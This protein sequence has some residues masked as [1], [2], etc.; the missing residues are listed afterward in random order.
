MQDNI[1]R[2]RSEK[3]DLNDWLVHEFEN[4]YSLVLNPESIFKKHCILF[5]KEDLSYYNVMYKNQ[6]A[7]IISNIE[8]KKAVKKKK[9]LREVLFD[10]SK[11]A[12]LRRISD[13]YNC[14]IQQEKAMNEGSS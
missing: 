3:K 12:K 2:L 13:D 10:F 1:Q 14:F 8:V 4:D 5:K 6:S 11:V 7:L 9:R